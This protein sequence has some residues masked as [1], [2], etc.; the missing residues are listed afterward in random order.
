VESNNNSNDNRKNQDP[1]KETIDIWDLLIQNAVLFT[2]SSI[3]HLFG[4]ANSNESANH[5]DH[6]A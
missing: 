4:A 2:Q 1:D 3:C 5:G 6:F